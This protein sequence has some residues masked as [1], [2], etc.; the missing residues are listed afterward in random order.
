MNTVRVSRQQVLKELK[1]ELQDRGYGERQITLILNKQAKLLSVP[2]IASNP[3]IT[4]EELQ[5]AAE[6]RQNSAK[7]HRLYEQKGR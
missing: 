2:Q 3:V 1:E 6:V 5:E 7:Q 4:A